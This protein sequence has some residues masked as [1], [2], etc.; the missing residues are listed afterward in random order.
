MR[1]CFRGRTGLGGARAC[2]KNRLFGPST[3]TYFTEGLTGAA[4]LQATKVARPLV[5]AARCQSSLPYVIQRKACGEIIAGLQSSLGNKMAN[6]TK[7]CAAAQAFQNEVQRPEGWTHLLLIGIEGLLG[8][9]PEMQ[10]GRVV[11]TLAFSGEE[12][13]AINIPA[14]GAS[15]LSA[16]E[17]S[18]LTRIQYVLYCCRQDF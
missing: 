1:F 3:S 15:P 11:A 6:R 10:S 9:K 2:R 8:V 5:P 4:S 12:K 7:A 14:T 16:F 13:L 18:R 17:L